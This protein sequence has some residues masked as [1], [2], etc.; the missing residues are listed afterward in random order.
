MDRPRVAGAPWAGSVRGGERGGGGVTQLWFWEG[1]SLV[2]RHNMWRAARDTEGCSH[3][4]R[5]HF[6]GII[7]IA[8]EHVNETYHNDQP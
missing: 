3:W 7:H 4:H 2:S 5:D 1:P 8:Q 6:K